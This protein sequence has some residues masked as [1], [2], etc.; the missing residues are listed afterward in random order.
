MLSNEFENLL[1]IPIQTIQ[2]ALPYMVQQMSG[3]IVWLSSIA[4]NNAKENLAASSIFRSAIRN[5]IQLF[6]TKYSQYGIRFNE[7]R[8]GYFD[9]DGLREAIRDVNPIL[10]KIPMKR[11]G[12][13]S[14][15]GNLVLQLSSNKM[16]YLNGQSIQ[17]DGGGV[18]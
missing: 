7:L 3:N 9:T 2:T 13:P 6:S 16:N 10:D 12:L 1:S 4:A 5:V 15:I 14:E 17:I 8:L 11:L 18:I